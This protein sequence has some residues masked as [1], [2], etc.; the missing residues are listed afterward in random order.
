MQEKMEI[1]TF[2]NTKLK[3][4]CLGPQGLTA[5][6]VQTQKLNGQTLPTGILDLKSSVSW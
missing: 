1:K 4:S 5:N 3:L 2:R 6:M